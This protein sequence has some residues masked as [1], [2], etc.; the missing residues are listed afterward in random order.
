MKFRFF[1]NIN[2]KGSQDGAA[3]ALYRCLSSSRG[4][5]ADWLGANQS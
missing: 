4:V 1:V 2:D 3:R 5:R